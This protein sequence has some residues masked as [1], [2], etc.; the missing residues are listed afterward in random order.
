V[1]DGASYADTYIL[2]QE[3]L[4]AAAQV[5]RSSRIAAGYETAIEFA[6]LCGVN[7]T[8]YA[9]HETARRA[10]RPAIARIYEQNLHLPP[11]TLVMGKALQGFRTVPIVGRIGERGEVKLMPDD[12]RQPPSVLPDPALLQAYVVKGRDMY[13]S[14]QDGDIVYTRVLSS[15]LYDPE[16][17]QGRECVVRTAAGDHLLRLVHIHHDGLATLTAYGA[18][19]M[20]DVELV[21]AQPVELVQRYNPNRAL[22]AAQAA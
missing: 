2:D 12:T 18:E 16:L 17:I 8:T 11:G 20:H 15:Q 22:A 3:D 19:P 6:D 21:A 4:D 10:I 7:R 1:P 14:V 5:L 9:H 13:P